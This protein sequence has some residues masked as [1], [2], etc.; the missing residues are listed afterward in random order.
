MNQEPQQDD[1][2]APSRP[3]R[4]AR[5]RQTPDH[6]WLQHT[7]HAWRIARLAGRVGLRLGL[8]RRDLWSLFCGALLHDSGKLFVPGRI[9]NKPG[10]LDEAEWLVVRRHPGLGARLVRF[11][12]GC[13]AAV[14]KTVL[15]HHER[16]DGQGYPHGLRGHEIPLAAQ[17]VAVCDV[18]DALCSQRPYKRAWTQAEALRELQAQAGQQFGAA[19][20]LA[21]LA[22]LGGT[23][24]RA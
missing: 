22:E 16:W 7:A 8:P 19:V 21:F 11:L 6:P 12:P 9:L 3:T 4:P 17:I 10:R 5:A 18:Y 20:V 24:L 13:P 15:H 1:G 2:G 14:V 23:P